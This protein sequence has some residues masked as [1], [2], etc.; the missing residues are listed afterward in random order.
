MDSY[1]DPQ[2]FEY[3]RSA[4]W[5]QRTFDEHNANVIRAL[6]EALASNS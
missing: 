1:G 6:R 5:E 3:D 2:A 4:G